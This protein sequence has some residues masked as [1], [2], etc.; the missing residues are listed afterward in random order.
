MGFAA[1]AASIEC[2]TEFIRLFRYY[3]Y[4]FMTMFMFIWFSA[5]GETG[6]VN[7]KIQNMTV[8]LDNQ[9]TRVLVYPAQLCV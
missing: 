4:N 8:F 1:V 5:P 2:R 9:C 6:G 3:F 7:I